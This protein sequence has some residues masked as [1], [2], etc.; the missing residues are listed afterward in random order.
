MTSDITDVLRDYGHGPHVSADIVH[1]L[2]AATADG[3]LVEDVECQWCSGSGRAGG[4]RPDGVIGWSPCQSCRG[5]RTVRLV[6]HRADPAL[7]ER[8]DRLIAKMGVH[9]IPGLRIGATEYLTVDDLRAAARI[10]GGEHE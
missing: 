3:P 5:D 6:V 2:A 7:A 8:L 9:D 4:A 10:I 1:R